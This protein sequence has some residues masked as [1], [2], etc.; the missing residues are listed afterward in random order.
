MAATL[1]LY[2]IDTHGE[3]NPHLEQEWLLTNGLGGYAQG[4]VVGCN[5]RRY[6]GLL[7][8]ATLPPVGRMML[9]NRVGEILRFD[10]QAEPMRELS[11]NQFGDQFH[12]RGD[13]YLRHFQ[14]DD[15]ARWE[16]QVE[17]VTV[18]KE[19]QML[20]L[21][22][23]IALRYT[24]TPDRARAVELQIL[25]FVSL[26]DFHSLLHAGASFETHVAERRVTVQREG[27]ALHLR[28]D[29]GQIEQ[30]GDWWYGHTYRAE[31][32]RGLDDHED[33]FCPARLSFQTSEPATI[34]LWAS[35]GEMAEEGGWEDQL[36]RRREAV[37]AARRTAENVRPNHPA[38]VDAAPRTATITRLLRAAN[39]FVVYRKTPDGHDGTSIIAGY[40]W[41]ADWGRDTMIALPGLVLTTGR[42]QQARQ[43]LSVFAQYISEG[44]IP[45]RFDDYTNEPHYNTVDASLWFIHAVYQYHHYSGD[46][47]TFEKRLRPACAAI[48]EG[49]R[50]GT[51]FGIR[52]DEADGLITQG[53]AHTQLTW[54]DA[55]CGDIAFTPR[56]GKAVEINALWYNALRLMEQDELAERVMRSF[57]EAF[58]I[59]AFRGLADVISD[60]QRD[61]SLRPNQI[62][63]VSL[64]HSPLS[65]DQQQAVVEVVRR[66]LLTPFG[67]RTLSRDNPRYHG[68][69]GGPPMQRDE[70]Y[71]N[72][73]IWPWPIGAFLEA[74]LKVHQHSPESLAQAR[75]WLQP[76]IDQTE[77]TSIGQI[78]EIY[79]ADEPHRPAGCPAQAWSVAEVLRLAVALQM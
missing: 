46:S 22:N 30:G 21:Q 32:R 26:R 14:L 37:G 9:L 31:T 51:R 59:N 23:A 63:A 52:M 45:N 25:P 66:E 19:L 12:P 72:G 74:Y 29:A 40:P 38:P 55:K 4:T 20:W 28:A 1:P 6:H 3:L 49:Y 5:T 65:G 67:L 17:G 47:E 39:D 41:F 56:Q 57:R 18:I 60:G 8:A 79:E 43:V 36:E 27:V 24:I 53:D 35:L 76:L 58:W 15:T 2:S 71:H 34:T 10:G 75:Q 33:L 13:G 68:H 54:M 44:M 62:F 73:T 42:L 78:H 70:A 69:Y 16:Y 7:C 50:R 48:L 11:I 64:P 77:R 61:N